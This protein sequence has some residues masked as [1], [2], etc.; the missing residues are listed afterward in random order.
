MTLTQLED[1]SGLHLSTNSLTEETS[2]FIDE[3]LFEIIDYF[4][5]MVTSFQN[6]GWKLG[7]ILFLCG[8]AW[9]GMQIC[10]G[11]MEVRK[12]W[13]ATAGKWFLFAFAL[14]M[15]PAFSYGLFKFGIQAGSAVSGSTISVL[16]T[17][18]SNMYDSLAL[19]IA[20][21]YQNWSEAKKKILE[22][23]KK[24]DEYEIAQYERLNSGIYGMEASWG[25]KNQKEWIDR[26]VK[27]KRDKI[28]KKEEALDK[29][30]SKNHTIKS[31]RSLQ[32]I[33]IIPEEDEEGNETF[34]NVTHTYKMNLML[35]VKDKNGKDVNLDIL[36]PG[37]VLKLA[38]LCGEIIMQHEW[39][40][41]VYPAWFENIK[42]EDSA[43]FDKKNTLTKA[44]SFPI[45]KILN[46][47]L[48]GITMVMLVIVCCFE[49]IQYIMCL[50]EYSITSTVCLV[51]VPCLLFDGTKDMANKILPTLFAQTMK[52]LMIIICLYFGLW[53]YMTIIND[54]MFSTAGF[55]LRAFAY[56][57][58]LTVLSFAVI[59]NAPKIAATIMTGSPQ[60]S[61]GEFVQAAGAIAAG[62]TMAAKAGVGTA[63]LATGA[64]G[65]IAYGA[66]QTA[67]SVARTAGAVHAGAAAGRAAGKNGFDAG[68]RAFG[69]GLA[70]G[71]RSLGQQANAKI[72]SGA[73]KL[74]DHRFGNGGGKGGGGSGG[75]MNSYDNPMK[76]R[77]GSSDYGSDESGRQLGANDKGADL[78][79]HRKFDKAYNA[80][81]EKTSLKDWLKNQ[82]RAGQSGENSRRSHDDQLHPEQLATSSLGSSKEKS[83]SSKASQTL[84]NVFGSSYT[85]PAANSNDQMRS[86]LSGLET[87]GQGDSME[88]KGL[89][90]NLLHNDKDYR[91]TQDMNMN[92]QYGSNWKKNPEA[93][94]QMKEQ[95][96][97]NWESAFKGGGK[98]KQ[99]PSRP[100]K[101]KNKGR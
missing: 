12:F 97:S 1:M 48:A 9:C 11:T 68:V 19:T 82:Y 7:S 79:A 54:M 23:Q 64:A 15:L 5:G 80:N 56:C 70:A 6:L 27:K 94:N 47:V 4:F 21:D 17:N 45:Q 37:A 34:E 3:A 49:L 63:K 84:K 53:V 85:P 26:N 52:L 55:S 100:H 61:M 87:T 95:F 91:A 28:A 67:G 88:A 32:E 51:L 29:E 90:G 18:L 13:I 43:H 16:E 96:G 35:K 8:I 78:S 40:N 25:W 24:A 99:Q 81:G 42:V 10:F 86:Q 98:S 83:Q 46:I 89:R 74:M 31:M 62:A 93:R 59:L 77:D 60:L 92:R 2:G 57:A 22:E 38:V 76:N 14:T 71:A 44:K 75:G 30:L 58:F 69:G 41:D 50:V 73:Q 39:D 20:A 36:S 33:L 65:S 101:P 66:T 72:K